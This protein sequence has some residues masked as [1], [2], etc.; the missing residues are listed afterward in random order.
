M[1][2]Q[3]R[4]CGFGTKVPAR[5]WSPRPRAFSVRGRATSALA[6]HLLR[7]AH[8]ARTPVDRSGLPPSESR[9]VPLRHMS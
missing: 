6:S 3:E 2:T 5:L 1:H 4:T 8:L 9:A 7:A